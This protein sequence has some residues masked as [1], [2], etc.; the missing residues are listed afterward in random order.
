MKIEL[1]NIGKRYNY[2]WIFRNINYEFTSKNNYVILGANGSGKSTLLQVISGSTMSSDG[3]ITY[4]TNQNNITQEDVF[5]FLSIATPYLELL[6]EFTLYESIEFQKQF[7]PY[8]EE[9]DSKKIIEILQLEKSANK[10]L[11]YFS[12]GMKQR[13]RLALA[14]LSKTPV[15]LLD[16][17]TSNL[18]KKGVDWYQQL[19]FQYSKERLIIVCSNQQE[20]EYVFCNKQLDLEDYKSF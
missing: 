17:P 13:V 4:E 11:K 9:L 6:E 10:Q 8:Y 19:I 16:E 20:H 1:T 12:S 18:D 3:V 7:K 14:I 5:S 15:L 2:E